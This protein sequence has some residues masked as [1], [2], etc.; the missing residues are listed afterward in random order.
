[1]NHK[2]GFHVN[3]PS[4]DVLDAVERIRPQVLKGVEHDVG[5][6]KEVRAIVPDAFII[7]RVVVDPHEQDKFADDPT[8]TGQAF[9]ERILALEANKVN[10]EGRPLFDAWE[11]YNEVFPESEPPDKKKR[12][13]EFQVAF[14]EPI[15][16]AGFEPIAMNFATGNLLG[17]DLLDYFQGTLETHNYL[18]FHEYDWPTMW[19]LHYQ[20]IQEKGEAGMWLALRYRRVMDEVRPVYGDKH[21]VIITECGM[22]Q[23]VF[24]W[25]GGQDVGWR[26]TPTVSQQGV[27]EIRG[28]LQDLK[29]DPRFGIEIDLDWFGMGRSVPEEIYWQS[30]MWYND[31][32]M[33]DQYVQAALLFVVGAI[34]PWE[35]FDHLGGI[36]GRLEALQGKWLGDVGVGLT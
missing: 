3:R 2:Y 21:T 35:S 10:Y 5:F 8:G 11:S 29:A 20:N 6:W 12:Y 28:V 34:H 17:D 31:E 7:G 1:M 27:E 30:L 24:P 25:L 26:S 19:R 15:I 36:I 18:G 14:A 13:N 23:G 9:A 16:Q 32:L 33:K 4:A 22:T